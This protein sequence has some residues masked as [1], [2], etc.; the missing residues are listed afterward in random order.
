[1][2]AEHVG[3]SHL[4]TYRQRDA[5]DLPFQEATFDVVWS[6]HKATLYREMYRVLA[7][8]GVLAI[9]DILAGPV[10]PIHFPVPWSVCPRRVF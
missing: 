7:P 3:L 6:Q 8:G 9:Y 2:L 4:T 5:L 10:D 1:M